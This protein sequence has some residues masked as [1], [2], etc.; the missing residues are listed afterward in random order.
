M[1]RETWAEWQAEFLESLRSRGQTAATV[2]IRRF[3]LKRWAGWAQACDLSDPAACTCHHLAD[4]LTHLAAPQPG[5]GRVLAV[6]SQEAGR[7]TVRLFLRWAVRTGRLLVDPTEDCGLHWVRSSARAVPT[8]SDIQNLLARLA[9]ETRY[10]FRNRVMLEVLYGTALRLSECRALDLGDVNL[11]DGW[12]RIR[13]AK[14]GMQ[15][16]VPLATHLTTVLDEY[17]T[18]GRVCFQPPAEEPALFL[19][20]AG[21][22]LSEVS[23]QVIVRQAG[24]RIGWPGLQTHDLRRAC[25]THLLAAGA[26]LADVCR[27]LG[28]HGLAN[29]DRYVQVSPATLREEHRRTHPRA[30]LQ[31]RPDDA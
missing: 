28:H 16:L 15:R 18:H 2:R 19:S 9:V 8:V 29:V 26:S 21:G 3:W 17:L 14:G 20:R 22:R 12:L 31:R 7:S 1:S 11:R 30:R 24:G 6:S 27:Q 10:G 25:A 5:A 23:M 4:F 13:R